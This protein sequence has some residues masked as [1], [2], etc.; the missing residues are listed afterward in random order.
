M[1]DKATE[2]LEAEVHALLTRANLLKL[3]N[4]WPDAVALCT[5]ALR[6]APKSADAHSLLGQIYEAQNNDDQALHFYSM[7]VDLNPQSRPDRERLD[8]L[9]QA[10]QARLVAEQKDAAVNSPSPKPVRERTQD[11]MDGKLRR[12]K[13]V[14]ILAVIGFGIIIA[15]LGFGLG[16]L[17]LGNRSDLPKPTTSLNAARVP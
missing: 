13:S 14:L 3:R 9:V 6:R 16:M 15:L 2:K 17:L 1:S 11:W 4:Q 7:A 10:R 12:P 8:K 5:E